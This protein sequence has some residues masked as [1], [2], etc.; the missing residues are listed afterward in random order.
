MFEKNENLRGEN[1]VIEMTEEEIIEYQKCKNDIFEFAKHF[2]IK[3]EKGNEKIK[4]RDYQKKLVK[5]LILNI[6]EKRNRI[7]MMG[8]QTG[9]TTI[10][11]VYLLWY[12]LFN[13]TKSIAVLANKE[14]QAIEILSR[15]KFAY[16]NLPLFIQQ[17][18]ISFSSMNISM[19]NETTIFAASSSSSA[20]RGKTVDLMLIDEF[21]HLDDNI[22]EDFVS[23]VFPTLSSRKKGMIL[24]IST[25]KGM[26]HFYDIWQKA[27]ANENEFIPAK[28][29]WYEVQGRDEEWLNEQIKS[30]GSIYVEQEYKCLGGDEKITIKH[31]GDIKTIKLKE[32]YDSL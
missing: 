4:F 31:N 3:S 6:P 21:A 25:P 8:R 2:S 28:I 22:A 11:T 23:S 20:I 30:Y 17:G 24:L 9:K 32:L 10:A 12:A 13:S 29:Q 5:T 15:I 19:E 7:F 26:N 18:L 14:A 1:E 27:K 16:A